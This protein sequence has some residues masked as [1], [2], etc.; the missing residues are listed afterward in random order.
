MAGVNLDVEWG[1]ERKEKGKQDQ[2]KTRH[3]KNVTSLHRVPPTA[4][5]S[6]LFMQAGLRS[7]DLNTHTNNFEILH[8][9]EN[10]RNTLLFCTIFYIGLRSERH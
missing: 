1:G 7:C 9:L 6:F 8:F 10:N 2:L 3:F 5:M 4:H